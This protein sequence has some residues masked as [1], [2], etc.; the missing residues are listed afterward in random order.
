MGVGSDDI[1][2]GVWKRLGE[3]AVECVTKLL[4]KELEGE[5]MPEERRKSVLHRTPRTREPC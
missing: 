2:L 5:K 3:V 4:T 1:T